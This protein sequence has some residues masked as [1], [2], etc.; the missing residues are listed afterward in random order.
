M[1]IVDVDIEDVLG[2]DVDVENVSSLV[3][4]LGR[5]FGK[6]SSSTSLR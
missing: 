2:F 5:R 3:T 1:M 6:A 4:T